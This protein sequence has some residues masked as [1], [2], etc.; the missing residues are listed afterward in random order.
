MEPAYNIVYFLIIFGV[1][2]GKIKCKRYEQF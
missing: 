2:E 1:F